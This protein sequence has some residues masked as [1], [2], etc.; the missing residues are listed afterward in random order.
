MTQVNAFTN[1]AQDEKDKQQLEINLKLYEFWKVQSEVKSWDIYQE[2]Y[3][4]DLRNP[5]AKPVLK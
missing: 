5:A 4:I 2:K 3:W 1:W